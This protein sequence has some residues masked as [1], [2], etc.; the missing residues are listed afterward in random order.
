VTYQLRR[1]PIVDNPID[2][3]PDDGVPPRVLIGRMAV[4]ITLLFTIVICSVVAGN[5]LEWLISLLESAR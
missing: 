5:A 4:R 3:H 1:P 2:R